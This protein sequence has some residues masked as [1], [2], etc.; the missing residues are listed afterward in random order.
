VLVVSAQFGPAAGGRGRPP[1]L[2][3]TFALMVIER[4]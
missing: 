3:G 4:Q 2:P 1:V